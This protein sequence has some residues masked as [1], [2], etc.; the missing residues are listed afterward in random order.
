MSN[1]H[2]STEGD[3][4]HDRTRFRIFGL[5][6]NHTMDRITFCTQRCNLVWFFDHIFVGPIGYRP[7]FCFFSK[8]FGEKWWCSC[9]FNQYIFTNIETAVLSTP[10]NGENLKLVLI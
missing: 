5:A 4:I 10:V 6:C 2:V 1:E 9:Q 8:I 3:I 7:I